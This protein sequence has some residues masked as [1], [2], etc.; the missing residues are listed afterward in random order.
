MRADT[1]VQEHMVLQRHLYMSFFLRLAMEYLVSFSFPPLRALSLKIGHDGVFP[2]VELPKRRTALPTPKEIQARTVAKGFMNPSALQY[3]LLDTEYR[4][5]ED[6]GTA[7]IAEQEV[8]FD[9]LR[10]L[11]A[12]LES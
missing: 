7:S 5:W 1:N 8:S 6:N 3:A 11:L 9:C 12:C 4:T 10:A 2:D